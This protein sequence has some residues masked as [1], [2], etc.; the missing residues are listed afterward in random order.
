MAESGAPEDNEL[1]LFLR[2]RRE[3]LTPAEVGL[4]SGPRRRTPGLRR[5]ELAMLAGV[6]VEYLT[7]LEQGRDR[8]PS[9]AVLSALAEALR[10]TPRERVHLN[11]L[12]KSV[13]PG[14]TCRGSLE[15]N[16][17]VRP[18]VRAVL[19]QLEPAPAAVLN[20]LGEV[21]ACT[22]GYRRLVG[23]TG[24]LD[25]GLPAVFARY[26]FTDPRA[27]TVYPDW[28][29]K[30][31][32]A[33][34]SLKQGPYRQDPLVVALIDE[35]TVTAGAEFTRRL[36]T[37]PGLPDT[38]GTVRM[39]HPEAGPL[40]LTYERLELSADDDQ[41]ILINLPADE[42]TATALDALHGRRPGALR[43]VSG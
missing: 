19:D 11:R 25:D 43:A 9:A 15:S 26:L 6:S 2:S 35:L 21:L 23:P 14:F 10:L 7:R 29:H 34:A 3:S 39:E 8:H 37:V 28:E 41:H 24:Q 16:R 17:L 12:V 33:V 27:R 42:A 1:G 5:A 13:T 18:A 20:R 32:K 38:N 30:A 36:A 4:P 31:D 40:R 22:D